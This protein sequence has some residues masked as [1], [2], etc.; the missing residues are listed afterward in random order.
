MRPDPIPRDRPAAVPFI[1]PD[2]AAPPSTGAGVS[3]LAH[4]ATASRLD[5]NRLFLQHGPINLVVHA[6]GCGHRGRR[7]LPG[8]DRRIFRIG[9]ARWS[10]SCRDCAGVETERLALPRGPIARRMAAAVRTCRA[11]FVTPHG[12]GR[13]CGGRRGCSD[14]RV[15][16][17]S[18]AC[19]CEQ[20]RRHCTAPRRRD[21]PVGGRGAVAPRG[22]SAGAHRHR[23]RFGPC[24][25]SRTSGWQGRSHSLGIADAVTVLAPSAAVADA[26]ATLIANRRGRRSPRHSPGTRPR[27]RPRTATWAI[28]LVTVSVP[29]LGPEAIGAAL[30]AGVR[31]ARALRARNVIEGA[32]LTLQGHWRILGTPGS[33]VLPVGVPP[34][35]QR[36]GNGLGRADPTPTGTTRGNA[37]T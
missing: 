2:G 1:D 36:T 37:L 30:D 10:T 11:G 24:A 21:P 14:P 3:V 22:D 31:A 17:R 20:R 9:S 25:A 8:A 32:A 13:R 28:R 19:L 35:L 29:P 27:T 18:R 15:A 5:G 26:A 4:G 16:V 7:I 23:V 33:G 6:A 12:G 34:A